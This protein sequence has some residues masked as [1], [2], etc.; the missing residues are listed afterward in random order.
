MQAPRRA[1]GGHVTREQQAEQIAAR[2]GAEQQV[3]A[4]AA[5]WAE[6]TAARAAELRRALHTR[7]L[8]NLFAEEEDLLQ[9]EDP[10]ELE[11]ETEA[12]SSTQP[13]GAPRTAGGAQGGPRAPP[14]THAQRRVRFEQRFQAD[15]DLALKYR[16]M[17]SGDHAAWQ[18]QDH[19]RQLA[20]VQQRVCDYV[21][22][23]A[24]HPDCAGHAEVIDWRPVLL[25]SLLGTGQLMVPKLRWA[26]LVPCR[27]QPA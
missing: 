7:Q 25:R 13:H 10:P 9:Y 3:A 17:F 1:L 12:G 16:T 2:Q 27:S 24:L 14:L 4:K 11:E 19:M 8:Q 18:E 23:G 22:K 21:G 5:A 6:A 20:A 15:H 26:H